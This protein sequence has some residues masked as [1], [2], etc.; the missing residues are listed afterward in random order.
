[1]SKI[2]KYS[3]SKVDEFGQEVKLEKSFDDSILEIM[4]DM[5]LVTS[6]FDDFC[7]NTG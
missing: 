6:M 3:F 5:Q 7:M 4:D 2:I 1:M